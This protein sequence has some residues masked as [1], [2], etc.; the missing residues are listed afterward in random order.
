VLF[1]SSSSVREISATTGTQTAGGGK[2]QMS[3]RGG[4]YRLSYR[5]DDRYLLELNG[6]YDGTSR[7]PKA[8]RFGF[9]PS[10]SAAWRVSEESFMD[11]VDFLDN[12]KLRG[13][14]GSLG[15]QN[16]PYYAY[17]TT[18]GNGLANYMMGGD[19]IP[20]VSSSGLVSPTLTW[21]TV[22]TKNIGVDLGLLNNKLT[23]NFDAYIRETKDMLMNKTYPSILGTTAPK[24]NAANL[25]TRGWE[26]R[27]S[28]ADRNG[29]DWSYEVGFNLSDWMSEITKYEN[30]TGRYSD[31]Y[32]GKKIGE[33]WGFETVGIIQDEEELQSMEDQSKIGSGWKVG[34]IRYK[35]LDDDGKITTGNN[36][37]SNPG[38][39]K[40]IGN[41]TPRYS[42]G[43]QINLT[44][45]NLALRTFFQGVGSRDFSPPNQDWQ[46]FWPFS[47]GVI[48]KR[49]I[50]MSWSEDNRDAYFYKPELFSGKNRQPQTR[51]LQ[52]AS[53][54]RLKNI[55]L[56]YTLPKQAL[57]FIGFK[58]RQS[59]Q[60]YLT[61]MNLW[62]YSKIKEPFDPEYV[63]SGTMTPYPLQ[64]TYSIGA[65]LS[66]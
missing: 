60:I 3:L 61:G 13:S 59:V 24:Q 45:K 42:Y 39:K 5:Y 33:I 21:E 19:K 28:Y 66:F 23:A 53:Y 7:F 1:R 10:F 44:Y 18:M 22:S 27:I 57:S 65:K 8:D 43:M 54:I 35:D 29:K 25:E 48:D 58:S 47:S 16:V 51:Y 36:T 11:D 9:F 40:I 12:L 37:I 56:N 34:N 52:D 17:I 64:R 41:S 62:E 32:I 38:D 6:R 46:W 55:S 14:Y 20:Y 2:S 63:F 50:E 4:F 31:Y 26:F 15:N 49:N 30:P